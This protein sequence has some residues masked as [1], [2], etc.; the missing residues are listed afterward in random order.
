MSGKVIR[1]YCTYSTYF[2]H[3]CGEKLW[4]NITTPLYP[5]CIIRDTWGSKTTKDDS[6]IRRRKTG[7]KP[8]PWK[9]Y[10][11]STIPAW[12]YANAYSQAGMVGQ[13][14]FF[15]EVA[16][17]QQW[18][19][20]GC[21][22]VNTGGWEPIMRI[23]RSKWSLQPNFVIFVNWLPVCYWPAWYFDISFRLCLEYLHNL[24]WRKWTF[25]IFGFACGFGSGFTKREWV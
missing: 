24:L 20:Q 3:P 13:N 15:Q 4:Y 11:S 2:Y 5:M 16:Y 22:L 6:T 8:W 19:V 10:I 17:V 23:R 18:T 12:L 1:Y 9:N 25:T 14:P 21:S 7:K